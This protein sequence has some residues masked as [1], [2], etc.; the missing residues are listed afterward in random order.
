MLRILLALAP[1]FL[2][3]AGCGGDKLP[4]QTDAAKGRE[5]MT[6][7][8]DTWMKGGTPDDLKKGSPP[9]VAYDPDWEAGSKLVKYAIDPTDGRAGV[10]LLLTVTLTLSRADGRTQDKTVNFSVAIGS[11]T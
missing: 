7:A 3:L 8:L 11:Q 5:G 1:S 6:T 9:V 4:P 2:A 10:D